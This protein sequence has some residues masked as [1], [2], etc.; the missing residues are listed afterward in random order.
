M[1]RLFSI[2]VSDFPCLLL[3]R[4]IRSPEHIAANLKGLTALEIAE[5]MRALFSVIQDASDAQDDPLA[6]IERQRNQERFRTA[7]SSIIGH[8]R[9]L[10]G[11]SLETAI[12]AMIKA[13]VN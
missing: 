5:K 7:G 3:F 12:E 10:V 11:K 9:S 1:A 2:P 8:L 13:T 6:A 4:D